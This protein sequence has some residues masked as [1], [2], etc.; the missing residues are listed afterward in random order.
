M[1]NQ[2]EELH[3]AKKRK[4]TLSFPTSCPCGDLS[5]ACGIKERILPRITQPQCSVLALLFPSNYI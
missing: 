3:K 5:L 1:A 4:Y 2:G